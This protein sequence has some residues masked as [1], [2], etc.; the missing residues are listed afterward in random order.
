MWA[1]RLTLRMLFEQFES[2]E[3]WGGG[4][5]ISVCGLNG[6]PSTC[7]LT[8][9]SRGVGCHFYEIFTQAVCPETS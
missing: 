1:K 3:R 5:K 6:T 8:S 2:F 9:L 7:R 4:V